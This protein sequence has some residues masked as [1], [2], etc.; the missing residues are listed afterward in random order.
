M[1]KILIITVLFL[2]LTGCTNINK[3][4]VA[5]VIDE[6][7]ESKLNLDNT[8]RTGYKYYL[9]TN[10]QV[11]EVSGL[12]EIITHQGYKYYMYVDIVSYYDKVKKA[13][14]VNPKSYLSQAINYKGKE[15]YLEV[16]SKKDK[17]LIEIM[18][19]YAKIELIVDISYLK[20]AIT[21]AMVILSTIRYNDDIIENMMGEDILN[22]NEEQ[23]NIFEVH[24]K[25]S[26]FLEYV[27]EFD[28]YEEDMPDPDLIN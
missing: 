27:Q 1:K 23:L 5:N 28:T 2:I 25:E 18:Y 6:V 24:G 7:K 13:Y 16:N 26:R 3:S 9:P 12:N 4:P 14:T 17:Y 21:N 19:N 15:G 20:E 22:F 8:Y 11:K 10:L